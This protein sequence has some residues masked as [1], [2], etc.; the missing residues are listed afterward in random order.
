MGEDNEKHNKWRYFFSSSDLKTLLPFAII[1][2][3][4]ET[5]VVT[6]VNTPNNNLDL[7]GLKY[8]VF[9]IMTAEACSMLALWS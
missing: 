3:S 5:G 6:M 9:M 4:I 7:K 1:L 8:R 2:R